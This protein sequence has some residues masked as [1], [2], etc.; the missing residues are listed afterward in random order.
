M[1]KALLPF[2]AFIKGTNEVFIIIFII[3]MLKPDLFVVG[4]SSPNSIV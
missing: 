1:A 2:I 3:K 4:D